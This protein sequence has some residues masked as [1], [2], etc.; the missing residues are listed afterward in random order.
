MLRCLRH[1]QRLASLASLA[2]LLYFLIPRAR[3]SCSFAAV[4]EDVQGKRLFL[5]RVPDGFD[6][7]VTFD[8]GSVAEELAQRAAL[9]L[10]AE[11]VQQLSTGD[12][13][14]LV[15]LDNILGPRL[16]DQLHQEAKVLRKILQPSTYWNRWQEGREDSYRLIDRSS[17]ELHGFR[18][19][20]T[21]IDLLLAVCSRLAEICPVDGKRVGPTPHAQLACFAEG[22]AGYAA[23]TDG[24][25]MADLDV[26]MPLDQKQMISSRRFTAILYLNEREWEESYAGAFRAFRSKDMSGGDSGFVDVW[27]RGGS[28]V[29]FRC[30]D[31]AHQVLASQHDRYALTMWFT[32]RKSVV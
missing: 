9:A 21:G 22:S 24:S 4:A 32:D 14:G 26:D 1:K 30:R 29:L 17:C 16:S 23:H 31:L 27:P 5:R 2:S 10:D 6:E 15:C 11:V 13:G 18:G 28:L 7:F 25:S 8:T 19:M 20:A 3:E 12:F